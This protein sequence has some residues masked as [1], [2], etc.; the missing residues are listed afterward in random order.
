MVMKK[1]DGLSRKEIAQRM[2][3]TEKTVK[4]HLNEAVRALADIL[5]GPEGSA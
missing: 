1:V 5:Y 4:W 2:G 3:V